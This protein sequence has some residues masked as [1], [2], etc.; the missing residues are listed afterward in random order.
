[1][2]NGWLKYLPVHVG[3]QHYGKFYAQLQSQVEKHLLLLL[4]ERALNK[5]YP[6]KMW[7]SEN[8]YLTALQT[9]GR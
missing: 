8:Q 7:S 3:R 6:C 5:D 4:I 9:K 2:S 1:M